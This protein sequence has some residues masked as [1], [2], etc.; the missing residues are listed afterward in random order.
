LRAFHATFTVGSRVSPDPLHDLA[1]L[2]AGVD[3]RLHPVPD[4]AERR[5]KQE[6]DGRTL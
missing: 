6:T 1:G 3:T 2:P 4:L 5:R